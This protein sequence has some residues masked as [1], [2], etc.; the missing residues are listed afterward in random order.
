MRGEAALRE[1]A[2]AQSSVRARAPLAP[3]TPRAPSA[4]L[5]VPPTAVRVVQFSLF[6][7]QN[8]QWARASAPPSRQCACAC[9]TAAHGGAASAAQVRARHREARVAARAVPEGRRPRCLQ[10]SPPRRFL[11]RTPHTSCH[12]PVCDIDRSR[13]KCRLPSRQPCPRPLAARAVNATN[14]SRLVPGRA[15]GMNARATVGGNKDDA[16]HH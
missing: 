16:A 14:V 6:T 15:V 1:A 3:H 11:H 4:R 2:L 13:S 10:S 12:V 8:D 5:S 7:P 9:G